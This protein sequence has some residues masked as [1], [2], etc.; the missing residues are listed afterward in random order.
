MNEEFKI[1][2]RWLGRETGSAVDRSFYADIGIAIGDE[3]LTV[4]EDIEASTVRN[5]FRGCAYRLATWFVANWWRLRWEPEAPNWSKNPAWS[6]AH[7]LAAAGGGYV[8][9]NVVFASDGDS[10]SISS[11]ANTKRPSF[12]PVRYLNS[13]TA[14]VDAGDFEQRIDRFLEGIFS[15]LQSRQVAEQALQTTWTE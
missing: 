13:V 6:V 12:E 2:Y 14:R 4:L 3:W 9:P 7:S 11:I 10:L 1:D 15:R 5:H 8:W